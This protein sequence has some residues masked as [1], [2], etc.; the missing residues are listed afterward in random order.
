[1]KLNKYIA[2]TTHKIVYK[3]HV[4]IYKRENAINIKG[5]SKVLLNI[6]LGV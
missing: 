5:Q 2:Y 1:M 3:F 6:F 4:S